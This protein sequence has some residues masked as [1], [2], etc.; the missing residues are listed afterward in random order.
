M[1]RSRMSVNKPAAVA[2]FRE[3]IDELPQMLR[4]TDV[5]RITGLGYLAIYQRIQSGSL[6][7]RKLAGKGPWLIRREKL[8]E[9][10]SPETANV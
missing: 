3:N 2:D 5:M 4:I 10:L 9:L 8:L 7:A 6:P 1:K